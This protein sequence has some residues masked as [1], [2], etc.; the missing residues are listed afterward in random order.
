MAV[1]A[2]AALILSGKLTALHKGETGEEGHINHMCTA[3][4]AQA[5]RMARRKTWAPF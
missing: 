3:L 1:V 4:A 5:S 2:E